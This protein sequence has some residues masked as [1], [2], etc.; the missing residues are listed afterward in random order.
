M[1]KNPSL[2]EKNTVAMT[3]LNCLYLTAM[4]LVV[5]GWGTSVH[6]EGDVTVISTPAAATPRAQKTVASDGTP[7]VHKSLHKKTH[8]ATATASGAGAPSTP[9]ASLASAS[10]ATAENKPVK[11][12]VTM[13][14][15]T[16][17]AWPQTITPMNTGF[18]KSAPVSNPIH[19]ASAPT[20]DP[21]TL[22]PA[23]ETGLPVARYPG[24]GSP[25]KGVSTY[26]PTTVPLPTGKPITGTTTH[27]PYLASAFPSS[28]V[29]LTSSSAGS[30]ASPSRTTTPS[31]DFVFTN[32]SKKT[33]V[34]YPWKTGIITTMFWIGEGSTPVSRTTNEAS[35]WDEDWMPKNH[36][37]DSPNNRNGYASGSHASTLNPFYVEL[38]FND[39]AFPDKAHRWLPAGWYR[40]PEGGKQVS[41]CKDRWV[42]IKNQR[43][44]ACYA[45]WEDVGPLRYDHAEYVFGSERPIG[46]GDNHAGLDVSP[47]VAKYLGINGDNRITSWRFVDDD[48]VQPGAWLKL[49]EQ[50]LLFTAMQQQLK[51]S[52]S[53]SSSDLPVQRATQPIDDPSNI[54]SN[55]KKVDQSK[56]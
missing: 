12:P 49:D 38:P 56:G 47:A 2:R 30:Y 1:I 53:S 10:P 44:D 42:E 54:D 9:T 35:S 37:S 43:G 51:R 24:M 8:A 50:A 27:Q 34:T 18:A 32:F 46:L 3:A 39:L 19:P 45:Q 25:I 13:A 20:V 33:K 26:F 41:A 17:P 7:V 15:A 55:K 4:A 22:A 6:A 14:A 28:I 31:P 16:S 48:D 29:P 36:G 23:V 5:L 21:A 52:S 11:K 40:R